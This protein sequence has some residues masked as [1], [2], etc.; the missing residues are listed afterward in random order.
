MAVEVTN[1]GQGAQATPPPIPPYIP[2][3]PPTPGSPEAVFGGFAQSFVHAIQ[4][5]NVHAQNNA[6]YSQAIQMLGDCS[7]QVAYMLLIAIMVMAGN[8]S[9]DGASD[10]FNTES[11]NNHLNE[12][13]S[14]VE[15]QLN[16]VIT[17]AQAYQKDPTAAAWSNLQQ[18]STLFCDELKGLGDAISI[19]ANPK[20]IAWQEQNGLTPILSES[21][22]E[23][24]LTNV[25]NIATQLGAQPTDGQQAYQALTPGEVVGTVMG[26]TTPDESGSVVNSNA[27][28]PAATQTLSDFSQTTTTLNTFNG[29]TMTVESMDAQNATRDF[30]SAYQSG[31]F[32]VQ[33]IMYMIQ[34][35]GSSN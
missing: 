9:N 22:A 25:N 12:I 23:N 5:E 11:V 8:S 19:C 35:A 10:A 28:P 6:D 30:T 31:K 21:D 32:L 33:Q 27:L 7:T 26:W 4:G 20:L 14:T 29:A 2:L 24:L 15:N 1:E 17:D 16:T 3:I 18:S 34:R 13:N